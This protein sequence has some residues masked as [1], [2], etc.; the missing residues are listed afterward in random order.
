M[1]NHIN[2]MKNN[3]K[4][5]VVIAIVLA[6]TVWLSGCG[7]SPDNAETFKA[8]NWYH[9]DLVNFQNCI[10]NSSVARN[11]EGIFVNYS[12]VCS[13]CGQAASIS[14]MVV[15]SQQTPCIKT[16]YCDCGAQTTVRIN[17]Y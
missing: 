5:S 8:N 16:Y 3:L 17:Q 9:N 7:G 13:E 4:M 10:I 1:K 12:S 14:S 2:F 11:S 15:V 6:A